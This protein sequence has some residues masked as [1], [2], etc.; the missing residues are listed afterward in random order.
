MIDNWECL[1]G[2]CRWIVV[3]GIVLVLLC[4]ASNMSYHDAKQEQTSYC[5]EVKAGVYPDYRGTYDD[6]CRHH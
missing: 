5:H 4:M 3:G 2:R 1:R 6:M